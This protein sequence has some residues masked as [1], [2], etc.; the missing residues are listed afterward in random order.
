MLVGAGTALSA[1]LN[2]F[3]G[4]VL[5]FFLLPSYGWWAIVLLFGGLF[6]IRTKTPQEARSYAKG[7]TTSTPL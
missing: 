4:S 7:E 5:V 6:G 2:I 3:L 1:L